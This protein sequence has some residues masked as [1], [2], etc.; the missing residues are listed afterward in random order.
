MKRALIATSAIWGYL[1]I[2]PVYAGKQPQTDME[3]F[4]YAVGVQ[5]GQNLARQGISMD[6]ESL[7]QAIRD[8]LDKSELKLSVPEM[9]GILA[10][11]QQKQVQLQ[12]E[13]GEKNR[14]EGDKFL[15]ENR[16]KPGIV[17]LPS[18]LQYKILR[19]GTGKKPTLDDTVLVQYKG[20]LLNG[21]VFDSS[22]SRGKP[23][24]LVLHDVIKG[25]QE[26]LTMMETGAKWQIF[27]PSRLAYGEQSAGPDIKP[28]S[29]L[30]FDIE[31]ISIN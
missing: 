25:W 15:A 1:A 23:T 5:I 3:K 14:I 11:F 22:Y 18:G 4:S 2:G 12:N 28:N 24:S 21:K 8:V 16:K 6:S 17:E 10:D 13:L 30:I 27:V 9:Q 19:K 7:V 26:A 20:S 29:A 31:L